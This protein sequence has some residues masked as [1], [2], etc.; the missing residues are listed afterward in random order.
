MICPMNTIL[1]S[2]FL[3][4]LK[5]ERKR[6]RESSESKIGFPFLHEKKYMELLYHYYIDSIPQSRRE[7]TFVLSSQSHF[8]RSGIY[9]YNIGPYI[10]THI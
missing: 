2:I 1:Y 10:Y 7:K 3:L 6:K 5:R 9:I 4:F 8:C